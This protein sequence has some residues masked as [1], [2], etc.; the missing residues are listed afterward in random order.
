MNPYKSVLS[1]D[2]LTLVD[3]LRVTT[4][5]ITDIPYPLLMT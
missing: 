2:H 4:I 5:C 1:L 3:Y